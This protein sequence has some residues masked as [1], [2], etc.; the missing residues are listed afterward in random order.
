[1]RFCEDVV[2]AQRKR[3][4]SP[5]AVDVRSSLLQATRTLIAANGLRGFKIEQVAHGAH[6]AKSALYHHF[7]DLQDLV[8]CTLLEWFEELIDDDLR[9][10]ESLLEVDTPSE[11]RSAISTMNAAI[12]DPERSAVRINRTLIAASAAYGSES[13][14]HGYREA[15][16][17]LCRGFH[18]ILEHARM[19]GL[20]KQEVDTATLAVFMLAVTFGTAFNELAEVQPDRANWLALFVQLVDPL[21]ATEP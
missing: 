16:Q 10:L 9:S 5:P 19:R 6:V 8:E 14:A 2:V 20:L 3:E 12:Y 4:Q 18:D 1:M 7:V 15:H 13:L 11:L 21:I 17:R